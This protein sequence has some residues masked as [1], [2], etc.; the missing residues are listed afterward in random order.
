MKILVRQHRRKGRIV[1]AHARKRSG[2]NKL[3]RT[4]IKANPNTIKENQKLSNEFGVGGTGK[5][6]PKTGGLRET[7]SQ[8]NFEYKDAL[9][10]KAFNKKIADLQKQ[11]NKVVVL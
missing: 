6:Y 9:E 11:I 5:T 4:W 2:A 3:A 8:A 7:M 1:K 10:R